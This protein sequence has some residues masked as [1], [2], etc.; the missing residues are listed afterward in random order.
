[1]SS[2]WPHHDDFDPLPDDELPDD[3]SEGYEHWQ[4]IQHILFVERNL[5]EL[6]K[7][8]GEEKEPKEGYL[9]EEE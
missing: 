5:K 8:I 7:I 4:N 6:E 2:K 1:M 9:E 3:D